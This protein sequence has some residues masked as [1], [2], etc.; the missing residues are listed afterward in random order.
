VFSGKT[1]FT[2]RKGY[3][4]ELRSGKGVRST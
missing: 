1:F 4:L 3:T 2:F